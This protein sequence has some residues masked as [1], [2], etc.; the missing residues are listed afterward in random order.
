MK[1]EESPQPFEDLI[2]Q[3][4]NERMKQ[5]I[6]ERKEEAKRKICEEID[7]M[8]D[9]E[10]ARLVLTISRWARVTVGSDTLTIE[11]HK[12]GVKGPPS[13]LST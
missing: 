1:V 7:R 8:A 3:G 13:N 4:F 6:A 5:L 2:L 12:P 10:L 9:E 11:I